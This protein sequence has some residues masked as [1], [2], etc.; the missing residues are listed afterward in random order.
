MRTALTIAGSD[1]GGGAG[2]QADL[3]TFAAHGVYGMSAITAVTAQNT[4]G[5][6]AFEALPADLVS[7]LCDRHTGIGG[8]GVIRIVAGDGDAA[9]YM[10]YYNAD[11]SAA[12]MCGNGIRCLVA[13]E[14]DA[15]RLDEGEHLIATKGRPVTI[16]TLGRNRITADMG[17]PKMQREDVP[18]TG[19][20]R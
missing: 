11:G 9:Y 20:K 4:R 1:S 12:E 10:D 17:A 15:G 6:T 18:M 3:K 14:L 5:V 2:I 7:A 19:T 13:H 8:D 16:R